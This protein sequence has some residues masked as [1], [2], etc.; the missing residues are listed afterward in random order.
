MVASGLALWS[1]TLLSIVLLARIALALTV[2]VGVLRDRQVLRD[3]SLIPLRDCWGLLLWL[4]SY[5]GDTVVWR[6]ERFRLRGG[7]LEQIR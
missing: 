7:R 3:I 4:W 5:A 6:G 2:G 1:L